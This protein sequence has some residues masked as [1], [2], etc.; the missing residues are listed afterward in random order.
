METPSRIPA[1]NDGTVHL[2]AWSWSFRPTKLQ[3]NVQL[4]A[5]KERQLSQASESKKASVNEICGEKARR[6]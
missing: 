5:G 4:T 6:G 3:I 2:L 1:D